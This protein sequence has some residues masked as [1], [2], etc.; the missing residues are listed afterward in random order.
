MVELFANERQAVLRCIYPPNAAR[1]QVKL[2]SEGVRMRP[3]FGRL[4]DDGDQSLL[5][6]NT[7]SHL[8]G[9]TGIE[10][11]ICRLF[12]PGGDG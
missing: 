11:G 1:V 3:S 4:G 2:F 12:R 9:G 8:A 10:A 5:I 6:I 7:L